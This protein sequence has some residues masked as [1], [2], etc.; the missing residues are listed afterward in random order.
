M[1]GLLRLMLVVSFVAFSAAETGAETRALLIGVSDYDDASGIENLRG[2]ANDVRLLRDVLSA[3]NVTDIA[4]LADG[5]PGSALPARAA[6]LAA[7][8]ARVE[9]TT[10]GDFVYIHLSGH[11]SRQ[12][13]QNGDEADGLDEV[14]LPADTAKS[15]DGGATIPNAIA[16]EEIGA[17]LARLTAKGAQVWIVIAACHA[18]CRSSYFCALCRS[19][20]PGRV[21][22]YGC[23]RRRNHVRCSRAG[24][25]RRLPRLLC[26]AVL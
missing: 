25:Q 14:F 11:G 18:V 8:D 5:V 15:T 9:R 26:G 2:P 20:R 12:M 22:H 24:R 3:R 17:V 21:G 19:G 7:L 10:Q 6:I 4:V 1:T 13:D 16:E 23:A